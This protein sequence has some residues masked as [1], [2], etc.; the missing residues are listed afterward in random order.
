MEKTTFSDTFYCDLAHVLFEESDEF[1][2]V[3]SPDSKRFVRVNEAGVRLFGVESEKVFF[4]RYGNSIRRRPLSVEQQEELIRLIE[5]DGMHVEEVELLRADGVPFKA[6]VQM[7]PFRHEDRKFIVVR[8]TDIEHVRTMESMERQLEH[9]SQRYGA[10]F[11]NATI[12]IIVCNSRGTIVSASNFIQK[13][14]HYSEEELVGKPIELLVPDSVRHTHERYRDAFNTNPQIRSMGHGRDLYARRKDGTVFPAEISLSYFR[15]DDELYAVAYIIDITYKKEAERALIEQKN[16]IEQ[17]NA[18]LEQKVADRTKALLATLHQLEQSKDELAIALAAE[19]ELGELKS[20]F[21]SMASHEF[22]T[23]LSAVLSSASLLEKYTTTE[24]QE[25]RDRH[26]QRIKSSVNHLNDILEEFLS[27]GKLEEGKVEAT[28]SYFHLNDLIADVIADMQSMLKAG[29]RV[30]A[31]IDCNTQVRLDKS[32]V[33]KVLVNLISNAVKYS[34]ENT[35]VWVRG[36]CRG[37]NSRIE[38]QDQGIGISEEDQKHLFERFFRAKN[39]T[40]FAGTGLGLHIVAKY[41]ELL[42]GTIELSSEL[43]KGT[44]VTISFMHEN[45]SAY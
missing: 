8:V 13:Q 45:H 35:T 10:V 43:N 34:G 22:R 36:W 7:S 5:R 6:R 38:V 40:N 2:G 23:P 16:R 42:N 30:E 19:R 28:Y 32:L 25:K 26:I 9:S 37:T 24:Q 3:Y 41:L 33:R 18:E 31:E 29:Q 11:T 44:T 12:G 4:E 39:A 14:F 1:V 27:V 20:R 15:Q 17:M 21:V